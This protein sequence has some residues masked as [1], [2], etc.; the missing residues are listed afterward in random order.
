M[1]QDFRYALRQIRKAPGLSALVIAT[2]ALGIGANSLVYSVLSSTVLKP[3]PFEDADRIVYLWRQHPTN[4]WWITPQMEDVVRWRESVGGLER[5]ATLSGHTFT[6]TG[7]DE[8]ERIDGARVSPEIFAL[9]GVEPLVGRTFAPQEAV[10]DPNVVIVSHRFW[11]NHLGGADTALGTTIQLDDT[12]YAVIGV[13]PSGFRMQSPFALS[14]VWTPLDEAGA[15]RGI[16][17]IGLMT[18]DASIDQV[19][20]QLAAFSQ[21]EEDVEHAVDAWPAVARRPADFLS[22]S[23]TRTVWAMQGAVALVLLIATTNVVNLLLARGSTRQQEMAVRSAIGGSTFR[24]ARQSLTETLTLTAVG[25]LAGW[26]IAAGGVALLDTL[27]PQE[28]SSLATLRLDDTVAA[29]TAAVTVLAGLLAGALPAL[30]GSSGNL[31]ARMAALSGRTSE[32]PNK[33]RA[34]SALVVFEVALSTILV[35]TAGLLVGSF[36]HLQDVDP[37][38]ESDNLLTMR[39]S[40]SAA[41]YG[42]AAATEQFWDA[43][44]AAVQTAVGPRASSV[45]LSAGVP[46]QMGV[47]F[48][49]PEREDGLEVESSSDITA[50]SWVD[51]SYFETLEIPWVAGGTFPPTTEDDPD[52]PIVIDQAFADQ[53]WPGEDAL[54]KRVTFGSDTWRRVVGIVSNVKAFGLMTRTEQR[55]VYYALDARD[56]FRELMITVRTT[57]NP[58][59]LAAAVRAAVW[60]VEPEAPITELQS[61]RERLVDTIA[62]PRFNAMLMAGLAAVALGLALVGV[63]GVLSYS[64]AK[65][66][67]ELGVRMALGAG[68]STVLAL[69]GRTSFALIGIGLALGVAG[70]AAAT[71]LLSSLLYGVTPGQPAAYA[72]AALALILVGVAATW[73]PAARATRV[74]PAVALRDD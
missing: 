17:A 56:S 69:V 15:E 45:T 62:L 38:F 43:T 40:I 1:F 13:M 2:M 26:A 55:Q 35:V 73:I 14:Q 31:Q 72:V 52:L 54:G 59:E 63:Y 68:R 61:M 27:R 19:N 24:L 65:R 29:A 66:T 32:E 67:H 33:R 34:R 23:Y 22:S 60:S 42:D 57:E 16:N 74:D 49:L 25:G 44:R 46:P 53:I 7:L 70:S 51:R 4:S 9:L 37:G 5:I 8:P 20:E 18:R 50:A 39:V 3:L 71:R 12:P 28:L 48:G 10:T 47:E 21:A 64:V 41:K 36:L 30:Q 11:Q 58:L 6:V